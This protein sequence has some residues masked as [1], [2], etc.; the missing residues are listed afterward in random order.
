MIEILGI[1]IT[2]EVLKYNYGK[3]R[4]AEGCQANDG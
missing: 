1:F 3:T 2:F 4:K